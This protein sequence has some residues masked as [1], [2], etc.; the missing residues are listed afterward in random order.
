M[1]LR[2]GVANYRSLK[3][4]TELSFVAT[5]LKDPTSV[6]LGSAAIK[7]SVLPVVLL[8]GANASG[9]SGL[10]MALRAMV[11]YVVGSHSRGKPGGKLAY[12]PFALGLRT[13]DAPT[14]FDCDFVVGGARY[15]YGFE[16]D[17]D[18]FKSERLYRFSGSRRVKLFERNPDGWSFGRELKG[19]NKVIA[20][21][22]RS[23]SLFVSAGAQ[24]GH[25]ELSAV[26][27]YFENI[28]FELN[29]APIAP[30]VSRIYS[31]GI[32]DRIIKFL[33]IA[34]TG[35]VGS[36]VKI[37]T[38]PD[39][40]RA[41][42]DAIRQ[43]AEQS[44]EDEDELNMEVREPDPHIELKLTHRN[45]SG[46][47]VALDLDSESRGTLRLLEVLNPV[48]ES[49]DKGSLLV[50]DELDPSLHPMISSE[51]V[52]LFLDPALN[53]KGA[54]LLATTHDSNLLS[55]RD[56]R[57]DEIWFAEKDKSGVTSIYPMTDVATRKGENFQ[58]GY[59]QGRYGGVPF[60]GGRA[61]LVNESQ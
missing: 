22:T 58:R 32:N 4:Y 45:S 21:L 47:A 10:L 53:S 17:A 37:H 6:V 35:I 16:F 59:L 14:E 2:F 40:V 39:K 13:K 49:L 5:T 52:S 60:L 41:V 61:A 3:D 30:V 26:F 1:L 12:E 29:A 54:Q 57:R 36:Q 42:M 7:E 18:E 27:K 9:K 51:I 15:H 46:D 33:E 24:N 28:E 25:E 20:S 43:V 44:M 55:V 19:Q 11:R 50:V 31:D 56:I 48:F 23:N 38:V 8:Y 34:D